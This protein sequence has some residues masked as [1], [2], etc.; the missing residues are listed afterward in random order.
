MRISRTTTFSISNAP[1]NSL[2]PQSKLGFHIGGVAEY[3][4][5]DQF[6]IAPELVI[7]TAGA[8]FEGGE[9][10]ENHGYTST[11]HFRKVDEKLMYLNF[12]ILLKFYPNENLSIHFGPEIGFLLSAKYDSESE[13]KIVDSTNGTVIYESSDSEDNTDVKDKINPTNLGISVGVEYKLENGLFFDAR[14]NLGLSNIARETSA[15][16]RN[17]AIQIGVGFFFN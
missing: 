4:F 8:T 12:P 16:V 9:E 5:N 10:E 7:A 1:E 2:D 14:Y 15:I 3:K 13:S 6:A 11:T 17:N